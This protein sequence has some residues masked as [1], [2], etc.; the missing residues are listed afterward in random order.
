MQCK[1]CDNEVMGRGSYCG[2]SC[3]TLYN[4]NKKR[5]TVTDKSVTIA[6]VTPAVTGVTVTAVTGYIIALD[7]ADVYGRT[8]VRFQ[9]D[10][11]PTRPV[12]LSETD[13]P[14]SGGRGKYTRQDGSVY[15]FDCNGTAFEV[16]AGKVYQT[17]AEVK[18]CYA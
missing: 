13:Q 12:P 2:P 10:Q 18:A 15:Q 7:E 14:H 17:T 5:N 4:R 6:A 8:A 16:T 11:W 1:N 3:K 9:G